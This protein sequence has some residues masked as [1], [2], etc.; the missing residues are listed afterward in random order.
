[1]Y[2][3][4]IVERERGN[5]ESKQRR[6]AW[7]KQEQMDDFSSESIKARNVGMTYS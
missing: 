6:M 3:G 5:L 7:Y 1:M 4:Q 2:Q